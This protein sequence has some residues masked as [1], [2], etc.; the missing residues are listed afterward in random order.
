[1]LGVLTLP[2]LYFLPHFY[3]GCLCTA[4][5]ESKPWKT[6]PLTSKTGYSRTIADHAFLRAMLIVAESENMLAAEIPPC[7][8]EEIGVVM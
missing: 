2:A 1:M 8:M 3:T 6:Y 5:T 4:R 7:M